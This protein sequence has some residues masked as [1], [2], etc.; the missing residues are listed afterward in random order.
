MSRRESDIQAEII[1]A[2]KQLPGVM[3]ERSNTGV[4][5]GI[6]FGTPGGPDLRLIVRGLAVFA[7]CKRPG[8]RQSIDQREWQL[9]CE[10][11]GG[12]YSVV[13]SV[14]EA[15]AAVLPLLGSRRA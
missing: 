6:R 4:R 2:L 9:R 15:L 7:E 10:S 12:R 5:G 3:V 14:D 8:Q 11:A 1:A 13:T